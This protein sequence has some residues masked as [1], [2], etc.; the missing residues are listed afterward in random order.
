MPNSGYDNDCH[1]VNEVWDTELNKWIMLDITNNEYWV[2][3]NG[4]SLSV[5]EIRYK[6]AMQEFCTPVHQGD[7]FHN[8]E[9]LKEKYIADFLYIM[10]NMTYMQYCDNYTVGE[11]N[12]IYLLFP[13]NLDTNYET[14]ISKEACEKSPD[15]S[16]GEY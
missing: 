3:E 16:G 2:D 7:N 12:T 13:E 5:L 14:M 6:G 9:N 4:M 10:K 15:K 8:L 1:V 11:S